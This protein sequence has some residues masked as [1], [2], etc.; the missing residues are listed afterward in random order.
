MLP[1]QS[2]LLPFRLGVITVT[3][4]N[5]YMSHR[6]QHVAMITTS[7]SL[8]KKRQVYIYRICPFYLSP[9][10]AVFIWSC[11]H[12]FK[13]PSGVIPLKLCSHPTPLYYF[14]VEHSAFLCY[15]SNHIIIHVSLHTTDFEISLEKKKHLCGLL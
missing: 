11:G 2:R 7:S 6:Q 12:G 13:S 8:K 1:A 4:Y 9:F 15:G 14:F 3:C 10:L 5:I